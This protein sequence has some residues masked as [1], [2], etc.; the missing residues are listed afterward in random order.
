MVTPAE[1]DKH[2][3]EEFWSIILHGGRRISFSFFRTGTREVQGIRNLESTGNKDGPTE[4]V[5]KK[6][7]SKQYAIQV[8]KSM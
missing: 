3:L 4:E 1:V 8:S 7:R 6:I 2:V 5:I